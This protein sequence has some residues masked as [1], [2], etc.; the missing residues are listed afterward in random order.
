MGKKKKW[1]IE[2]IRQAAAGRTIDI[3][4]Q[5]AGIPAELLDGKHHPCPKCGGKDRFRLIDESTGACL[6]NQCF[7]KDNGDW[8]SVC[9]WMTGKDFLAIVE[10]IAGLLGIKPESGST[11]VDPAKDL[12][13]IPWSSQLVAFLLRKKPGL[14]E[15]GLLQSGATMKRYKSFTV[16]CWPIIGS[17]LDPEKPVG[18]AMIDAMG[19]KLPTWDQKGN[20]TGHKKVKITYGSEPGIIGTDAVD[21]IKAEG[22]VKQAWKVEGITDMVAIQGLK[23]RPGD[24]V[25]LTN[26]NGAKHCEGWIASLLAGVGCPVNVIHDADQPGEDGSIIWTQKLVQQDADVTAVKLPYEV[27]E[28]HG[29]DVRD[30]VCESGGRDYSD[31][32]SLAESHGKSIDLPKTTE[33]EVD[34]SQM[35]FPVQTRILKKLGLEVLYEEESGAIRVFSTV[36]RK[37]TTIKF[38]SRLRHEDLIQIAGPPA[39]LHI[40][41]DPQDENEWKM[42][43]VKKALSLG[44][45]A[46]RGRNDEKGIGIWQ[47][48]DEDGNAIDSVVLVGDTQAAEWN[49]SKS[50]KDIS[51]PRVDGLVMDF[52]S[53]RHDWFDVDQMKRHLERSADQDW[54]NNTI[55]ESMTMF[56]EWRWRMQDV[57]PAL[58]TGLVMA[59]WIQTIWTWRPLV[60]VIGQS[61][62]GKST[63]FDS[64]GGGISG[65]GLFSHLC[66]KTEKSTEAGI[67]QGIGNTSMVIMCD[68]FEK[69]RERNRILEMMRSSTR[70]GTVARGTSGQ[71]GRTF[72]LRHLGWMSS[73][74]SGL[75]KQPDRNRFIQLDLLEAEKGKF[76]MLAAPDP[77][78]LIDLGQRLL[79]IATRNAVAAKALAV[80]LKAEQVEGIDARTVESYAVPASIL[81]LATGLDMEGSVGVLRDL[82][83][84]VESDEQG[85]PDHDTLI[86]DILNAQ[87]NCGVKDGNLSVGQI[88]DSP[89]FRNEHAN[90]LEAFGIRLITGR[91]LFVVHKSVARQLLRGSDWEGQRIDQILL[92]APGAVKLSQRVG[93]KPQRGVMLPGELVMDASEGDESQSVV[94]F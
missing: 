91:G 55:D 61:N 78:V 59:S 79:A 52:G 88:I 34:S 73:T 66:F 57:C 15:E 49:G 16:V 70:G 86:N 58:M 83:R 65:M 12:E 82:L 63:L 85:Q 45:S 27:V 11:K 92:R 77:P 39:M 46:L 14:T 54:V 17:S 10:L 69:S 41:S 25:V 93:S 4:T 64:L 53:G 33:G 36:L 74:E 26:S 22:F 7:Q 56:G 67:R 1:D 43:D 50:L 3:L 90:R 62:C 80:K 87:V 5:V 89:S 31:M 30:W 37:S 84:N 35:Q 75:F 81:G 38:V 24:H 13:S 8:F 18:Y 19:G 29:S 71:G 42:A 21:K 47:G 94:G 40:T 20:V 2:L 32:Q 48:I 60:I 76:G 9:Q 68:E 28:D 6:C 72:S 51:T 23:H 44:A